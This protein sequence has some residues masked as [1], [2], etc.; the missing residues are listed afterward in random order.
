MCFELNLFFIHLLQHG[1][2]MER[3]TSSFL[4][5][6]SIQQCTA[7]MSC[8]LLHVWLVWKRVPGAQIF[9]AVAMGCVL[10]GGFCFV[11]SNQPP[12]CPCEIVHPGLVKPTYVS[13][14]LLMYPGSAWLF[15]AAL[16]K[17]LTYSPLTLVCQTPFRR[18]RPLLRL[19]WLKKRRP[20]K[21][22]RSMTLVILMLL[23]IS[24]DVE[25]N[26][27]DWVYFICH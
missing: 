7:R 6:F 24:S 21:K 26:P 14:S 1:L 27:A 5:G 15:S 13:G 9:T 18:N 20:I 8:F 11:Q 19:Q 22:L 25:L 4:P 12:C 3:C 2:D 23:I 10:A 16:V 17:G